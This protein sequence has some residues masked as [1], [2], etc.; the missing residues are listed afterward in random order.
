MGNV[1]GTVRSSPTLTVLPIPGLQGGCSGESPH[2]PPA[3]PPTVA[4][5]MQQSE[6]ST[7]VA[8]PL[9]VATSAYPG[10]RVALRSAAWGLAPLT[11]LS[12]ACLALGGGQCGSGAWWRRSRRRASF[13]RAS[14]AS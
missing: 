10:G 2:C 11:L 12:V 6:W 14:L 13:S 7:V 9:N 4:P 5:F 8:A 1:H 3:V